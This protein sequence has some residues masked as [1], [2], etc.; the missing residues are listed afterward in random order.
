MVNFATPQCV[1]LTAPVSICRTGTV[2]AVVLAAAA[3]PRHLALQ[4]HLSGWEEDAERLAACQPAANQRAN[5]SE[6]AEKT[7][8]AHSEQSVPSAV[9][10]D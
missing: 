8:I 2:H 7:E 5:C 6:A 10:Q 4:R 3:Q 9:W 1:G